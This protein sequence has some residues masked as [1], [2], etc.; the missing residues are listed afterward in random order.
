MPQVCATTAK[1]KSVQ[2]AAASCEPAV[3]TGV[4]ACV[5][6]QPC[7]SEGAGSGPTPSEG[8]MQGGC[9]ER[10]GALARQTAP[11]T[12]RVRVRSGA[13]RALSALR[14]PRRGSS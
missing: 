9:R 4:C 14:L 11:G 12:V 13:P 6:R 8:D 10:Q 2:A 1:S 3:R 5:D 7:R